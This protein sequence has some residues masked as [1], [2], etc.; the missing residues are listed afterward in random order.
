MCTMLMCMHNI[1]QF[2]IQL[3]GENFFV[4]YKIVTRYTFYFLYEI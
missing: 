2:P 3:E 4:R 1:A